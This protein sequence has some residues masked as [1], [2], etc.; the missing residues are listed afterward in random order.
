LGKRILWQ[1]KNSKR[2]IQ[3]YNFK[4]KSLLQKSYQCMSLHLRQ[5]T[6]LFYT[7]P[8]LFHSPFHGEGV[9]AEVIIMPTL[10]IPKDSYSYQ[11]FQPLKWRRAKIKNYL[12]LSVMQSSNKFSL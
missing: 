9:G 5:Q 6:W 1:I 8:P 2:K 10:L 12:I 4:I 11:K 3:N 7:S